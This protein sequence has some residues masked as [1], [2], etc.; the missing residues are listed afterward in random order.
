VD[1]GKPGLDPWRLWWDWQVGSRILARYGTKQALDLS[2]SSVLYFKVDKWNRK[3][4]K[5]RGTATATAAAAAAGMS[6]HSSGNDLLVWLPVS[7]L[8]V[9]EAAE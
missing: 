1:R 4:A 9:A 2:K 6:S 5:K 8:S 3:K 7:Q